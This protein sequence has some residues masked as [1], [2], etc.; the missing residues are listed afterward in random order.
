[1]P[2]SRLHLAGDESGSLTNPYDSVVTAAMIMTHNPLPLCWIIPRVKRKVP[3]KPPKRGQS[4]EFK[5]HNTTKSARKKVFTNLAKEDVTIAAFSIRKGAQVVPNTPE[6]YGLLLCNLFKI[7][8]GISP[9]DVDIV[10]DNYYT[11]PHKRN[12]LKKIIREKL[13]LDTDIC[14]ADS[15]RDPMVQLADFVAGAVNFVRRGR[16]STYYDLIRSCIVKDKLFAWKD[17]RREWLK[18]K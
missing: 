2:S 12:A 15:Q 7:G 5:F 8:V 10:F 16:T 6:N 4:S 17:A 3:K 13:L 11:Q 1:M 9:Q 14:F 18:W